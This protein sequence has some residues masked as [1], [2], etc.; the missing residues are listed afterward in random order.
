M[1]SMNEQD[2]AMEKPVTL[3][4]GK[5]L[6]L[7]KRDSWEY[8]ERPKVTGIVAL[9]AITDDGKLLLIEQFRVPFDASVIELPAGLAGDSGEA[10]DL[11]TAAR[12]ELLEETGY[13]ADHFEIVGAG[14]PSAGMSTEVVTLVRATGLRRMHAG[15]GV[16]GEDIK[17]H[18]VP[19]A[20]V[21]SWLEAKRAAGALLDL[22]VYAGLAF[23]EHE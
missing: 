7:V 6:R 3:F 20:D 11:L 5:Y 19:L 21:R 8:V 12:R 16:D 17:T 23:A 18:E 4:A 10:E 13:A 9:I 1:H 14:A 2:V 22:K 15:G